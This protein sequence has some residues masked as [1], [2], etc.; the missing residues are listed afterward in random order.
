M[1]SVNLGILLSAA[2][3]AVAGCDAARTVPQRGPEHSAG[4]AEPSLHGPAAISGLA[5]CTLCHG[6]DYGGDAAAGGP[7]CT[8]CHSADG[9]ADWQTNCTF[10]HGTRTAGYVASDLALAAPP[11]GVNGET[12]PAQ[13]AVGA[14]RKHLG[15]GSAVSDGV[16]CDECHTVP[17]DLSHVDGIPDVTFGTLAAQGG[18]GAAFSGGTCSSSYCHGATLAGG[19]ATAPSWTGSIA[20]DA[21]HGLPPATGKLQG[22]HPLHVLHVDWW[23]PTIGNRSC[24]FCHSEIATPYDATV[25]GIQD[26]AAARAHHVDGEK[27]VSFSSLGSWDRSTKTCSSLSCHGTQTWE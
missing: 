1:R 16:S 12:D 20:C 15:N 17:T 25:L 10:C 23:R 22:S 8:S 6:A 19:T 11:E 24:V 21:C 7:S 13:P 26:T 3:L 4:F 18:P 27:N 2:S 9:F 14:H 5:T